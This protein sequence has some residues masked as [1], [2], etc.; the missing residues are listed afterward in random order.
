V[1]RQYGW[2]VCSLQVWQR[3]TQSKERNRRP[4]ALSGNNNNNNVRLL[5]LQ[6]ERYNRTNICHAGQH[7][8]NRTQSKYIQPN[9]TQGLAWNQFQP[10]LYFQSASQVSVN[11]NSF[12]VSYLTRGTAVANSPLNTYRVQHDHYATDSNVFCCPWKGIHLI[13]TPQ[14][15]KS[16]QHDENRQFCQSLIFIQP[17][18]NFVWNHHH[19]WP[20]LLT[21]YVK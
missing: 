1:I 13:I 4:K 3:L 7:W 17:I 18:C 6:S 14:F 2:R 19:H 12:I 9:I 5:Q 15:F 21:L 16:N 20:T 11:Y 8:Y 10:T